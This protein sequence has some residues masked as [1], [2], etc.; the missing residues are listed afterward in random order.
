MSSELTRISLDLPEEL[1]SWLAS[2]HS[3]VDLDSLA[4]AQVWGLAGIG[5]LALPVRERPLSVRSEGRGPASRFAH[6]VGL[7]ELIGGEPCAVPL[8]PGR[9]VRLQLIGDFPAIE[10]AAWDIARMLIAGSDDPAVATRKMIFYVIVELLRNAIQHSGDK[11]G[12]VVAAQVMGPPLPGYAERKMVQVCVADAGI[13]IQRSLLPRHPRL[14]DPEEALSK[15][16]WPHVSG[17]FDEGLTGSVQNAGMGLFFVAEMAKLTAGRLL[18]A[19]RGASLSL[20][21]DLEGKG[22]HTLE[23][24][25]PRGLGFPGTLVAFELPSDEV[26]DYDGLMVRISKLAQERT[27]QRAVHRWLRFDVPPPEARRFLVS[28]ASEDTVA[29]QR[30]SEDQLQP[31]LIKRSPISLNF[32]NF[33]ICTQSFLHALLFDAV[34]VAWARQTPIYIEKVSPA[35]RSGLELLESYALGG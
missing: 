9:T 17:A 12:G 15:A 23:F 25:K 20:R 32:A 13:G 19:S 14:T 35:V 6:A 3:E 34:R 5:S 30:F 8:E 1:L 2:G 31:L 7:S 21:G 29:A 24:L 11:L 22:Q 27:P 18:I 16:L 10:P 28:V 4:F 26:Q 33:S